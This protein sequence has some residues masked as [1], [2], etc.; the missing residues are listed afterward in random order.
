MVNLSI[1]LLAIDIDG[2][3]L[4]QH[5]QISARNLAAIRAAHDAGIQILLATGRRHQF[6][7]PIAQELGVPVS[8]ISSNG[9]LVRSS[10]G[11]VF[12]TDRLPAATAVKLILHMD[13]YR[14]H[15]VLTFDRQG[16]DAL[17]LERTDELSHSIARWI[18][19]NSGHI[20][21]VVPLEDALTEDPIQV[22]Y[23]GGVA[24]MKAAQDHLAGFPFYGEIT[25]LR[26]QYDHRDLCLLD[27]LNRNCTKGH[28]LRL[29]AEHHGIA[30]E[31]VMA[32]GDNYNDLEMLE[33]AG[34]PVIMGNAADDLKQRG[35]TVTASHTESG[36]AEAVER[37]MGAGI[38]AP[39]EVK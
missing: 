39:I 2:T 27:I 22:M 23:C 14:G 15:A 29:W 25:L 33:F 10:T 9:A 8:I 38:H 26:T 37:M 32:I 17:V 18:E 5:F 13:E 36:V 7:L 19:K 6:A 1:R 31:Q 16:Q 24:R 3:L 34:L 21:Y 20:R 28:A 4:D 12:H 35:W 30:P 11:A